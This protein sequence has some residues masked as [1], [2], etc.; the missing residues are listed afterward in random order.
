MTA[1]TR[2]A[3]QRS[4]EDLG[5]RL[6]LGRFVASIPVGSLREGAALAAAVVAAAGTEADAHLRVD[7]RAERVGLSVGPDAGGGLTE[8]DVDVARAIATAWGRGQS[9]TSGSRPVETLEI[10]IDALDFRAIKPFWRAVLGYVDEPGTDDDRAIV[11]PAGQLPALW[12]Q[13]MDEPRPQRNRIHFDI[14]VAHDEARRRLAA[15]LEAGGHLVSDA[16]APAFW[17]LADGEDNEICICTW[18][19]RDP[20]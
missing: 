8:I 15:A 2:T 16:R 12:F 7:V 13:Q 4:V 19:G 1:L 6:I 17:I 5:W 11:D 3:A 9:T 10:A 14:A 18:E 20:A